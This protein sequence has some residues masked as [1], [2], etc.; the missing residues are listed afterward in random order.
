[1]TDGMAEAFAVFNPLRIFKVANLENRKIEPKNHE[2][3][4]IKVG[5]GKCVFF[6][7]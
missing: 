6:F 7:R 5:N 2:K 3:C 1:M 4:N